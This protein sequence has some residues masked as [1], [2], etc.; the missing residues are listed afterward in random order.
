ML[1]NT[2]LMLITAVLLVSC[3]PSGSIDSEPVVSPDA[4]VQPAIGPG[5]VT[6]ADG[7]EISEIFPKLAKQMHH[8][9]IVRSIAVSRCAY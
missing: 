7:V 5:V 8:C 3:T 9:S 4:A 6:S 1:R 2:L